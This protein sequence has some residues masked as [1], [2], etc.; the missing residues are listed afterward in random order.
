MGK[1]RKT[2]LQEGKGRFSQATVLSLTP[3]HL[4][5]SDRKP[6]KDTRC[7]PE[8]S[9]GGRRPVQVGV[10]ESHL[11]LESRSCQLNQPALPWSQSLR[12]RDP[13]R[14]GGGLVALSSGENPGRQGSI[15]LPNQI[16]TSTHSCALPK[17]SPTNQNPE[18]EPLR[19]SGTDLYLIHLCSGPGPTH[20][21]AE[22]EGKGS[23]RSRNWHP[24]PGT[25]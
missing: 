5:T 9:D 22:R 24:D 12:R 6:G 14:Q 4:C 11:P 16:G 17:S 7:L 8:S 15:C 20:D 21:G 18:V 23:Q 3:S 10:I 25:T 19:C 2:E 1:C 13:T